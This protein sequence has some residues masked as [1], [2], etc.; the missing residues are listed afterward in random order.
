MALASY[1]R[2]FRLVEVADPTNEVKRV[3]DVDRPAIDFLNVRFVLGEPGSRLSGRWQ[4]VY[5]G[6]DGTLFQR[7][8]PL[9]RFFVP[10]TVLGPSQIG[11]L[12]S[13]ADFRRV[14][15]G[16]AARP[17]N[18]TARI[19]AIEGRRADR[20]HLTVE[21]GKSAFIASSE[22]LAPGWTVHVRGVRTPIEPVNGAFI[23]F[24]VPPGRSRVTVA[25]RPGSFYGAWWGSVAGAML[26]FAAGQRLATVSEAFGRGVC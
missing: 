2:F 3:V 26:L 13:I 21:A 20:F 10:D 8:E 11:R 14:V 23:G 18:G 12:P 16:D 17:E 22:P 5:D 15:V 1:M 9:A 19:T 24:V 25:Y 4:P 6:V 7:T